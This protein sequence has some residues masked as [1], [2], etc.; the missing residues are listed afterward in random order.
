MKVL[1]VCSG[2]SENFDFKLH[3][4]FVYEQIETIKEKFNIEYDTFLIKGKGIKGYL[5][6]VPAMRQKIK[7]FSPD[8]VHAHFG[9]SGLA[10]NLQ[11]IVPVVTTYHGSDAYLPKVRLLSKIA[12]GL[13]G[14]NIYVSGKIHNKIRRNK[15]YSIIPC[16]INLDVFYPVEMKV[17]RHKLNFDQEKV[18]VIF[19]SGFDNSVKNSPL[20]F[21]A[22]E[23]LQ[24]DI[25]L[26]ELKNKS[27]EEVNLLLNACNLLLLTSTSEGSPQIIKEA[28][29]CNCPIVSTDV[30][31][32]REVISDTAGC[33]ISSF[34][35]DDVAEK[36][37]LAI[38][39]NKKTNGLEKVKHF[40][41]NLI[42]KKIFDIYQ[43]VI[44]NLSQRS[45]W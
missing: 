21:S 33:Y 26:I 2:N 24:M 28:M 36:I 11:R 17:A 13:S 29:A 1:I 44:S 10:A 38:E 7:N 37:K 42:A 3:Q 25:K 22:L 4:A 30:G 23:L 43:M 18:Y 5:K 27:R 32:V 41:N 45:N 16:G 15:L 31:D 34:R 19:S 40:D 12:A 14:F 39:F 6:S 20:A 35:P 8:I 9:I